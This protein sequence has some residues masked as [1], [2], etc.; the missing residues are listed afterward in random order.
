MKDY[1]IRIMRVP[2][3]NIVMLIDSDATKGRIQGYLEKYLP[4]NVTRETTLY[5]YF[6]GHGAPDMED[7]DPYLVPYDGDTQFL[8]QTGYKLRK[9]YK[10]LE[11][12]NI[13]QSYVFLDSCFSGTA[14]R[15]ADMLTQ[16]TRPA[17]LNVKDV[18]LTTESIISLN[19]SSKGQT[20]NAYQEE[21]HGLFTYY[22]L[23][24][25]KGE[26]DT[27]DDKWVSIKEVYDYV[28]RHVHRVARR[29]GT[30][31]DPS[32]TPAPELLKDAAI[33]RVLQ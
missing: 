14:S 5:V 17:L 7:G 2:E 4:S 29:L 27:N 19:A 28:S 23:R 33:G 26:A 6:A 16:G 13:R 18:E 31:Q 21:K 24:A 12:L 30:E 9:L 15:A 11:S 20:S 32:I 10:D 1:F 8:E 25:L 22:L 3:E